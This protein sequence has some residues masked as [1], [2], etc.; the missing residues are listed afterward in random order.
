MTTYWVMFFLVA[1]A[2]VLTTTPGTNYSRRA[3]P[4][5][6]V[7]VTLSVLVGLRHEVGGD[8]G[9]YQ[10]NFFNDEGL[11][12]VEALQG[13][14]AGFQFLSWLAMQLGGDVHLLN[15]FCGILFSAGLVV[16]CRAQPRP[17]LA[18]TVAVPYLVIVVAMGYTRQGVAIGLTMLGM[19][20]L[21]RKHNW[22]FV[23]AV[24]AA[25]TM[26]KSAIVLLPLAILATPRR[27][28]WTA[29]WA[30]VT[31]LVMYNVLIADSIDAF[32]TNYIEAEY[33]SEGATVRIAMNVLPAVI[34]LAARRRLLLMPAER[35]L[36]LLMAALAIACAL[37]LPVAASSTAVDRLA[38]YLIP[39][40][41]FTLSR[42]PELMTKRAGA[43][44]DTIWVYVVVLY[45]GVVQFV[46]LNF[47]IH[48]S[49]WLPYKSWIFS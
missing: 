19:V 16:F 5:F 7:F 33:T 40:Q 6:F 29:L 4:W 25:A 46:W 21:S 15:L 42:L 28:I 36:W 27:R 38:L 23:A 31:I 47:A 24:V 44:G 20:A 48:A 37:W 2:A 45:Y 10:E 22:L 34:L 9:N 26:H 18:L 30:G 32:V 14:D 11:S 3:I 12:L 13:K 49:G 17:W 43:R 35:N 8:W 1:L 39:L 41:L